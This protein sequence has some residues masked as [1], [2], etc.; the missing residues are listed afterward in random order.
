MSQALLWI[1]QQPPPYVPVLERCRE[2]IKASLPGVTESIAYGIPFYTY[3]DRRICYLNVSK[4]KVLLGLVK[5]KILVDAFGMLEGDLKEVRYID[6][7]KN[8][9]YETEIKFYLHEFVRLTS[10]PMF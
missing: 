2:L 3:R 4:G 8:G 6:L 10:K 9:Q 7:I 5:G 1:R